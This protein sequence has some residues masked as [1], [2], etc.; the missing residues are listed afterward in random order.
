MADV[1][2]NEKHLIFYVY[3]ILK[4]YSD[5]AHP[6]SHAQIKDLILEEYQIEC[7]RQTVGDNINAL[8]EKFHIDIFTRPRVGSY[9]ME[10]RFEAGEATFLVDSV[11]S[12]REISAKYARD[13]AEK[14]YADYSI[15]QKKDYSY[16]NKPQIS[17][18]SDNRE[19]FIT[20][21]ALG[22]AVQR[23]CKVIFDY[24]TYTADGRR[25]SEKLVNPYCLIN[26]NGKYYLLASSE[27]Q[28]NK[29]HVRNYR[30]D[31]IVGVRITELPCVE[32]EKTEEYRGKRFRIE[33]Y[34]KENIYMFG[35]KSVTATLKLTREDYLTYIYDWFGKDVKKRK[36]PDGTLY[37]KVKVNEQA[38]VYWLLQYGAVAK[39][40]TPDSTLH[41]VRE[42]LKRLNEYYM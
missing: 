21:E 23:K 34:V 33:E 26:N 7:R 30:V 38:L 14:I 2:K 1:R 25:T 42:E 35:N 37:V 32:I 27:G 16:I 3:E 28:D 31:R 13:L 12:N 5:E 17:T 36:L 19:F 4:K 39:L 41:K 6:L 9:L 8:I 24:I 20:I 10:R 29:P 18:R 40:I 22:D 15:H 11:F